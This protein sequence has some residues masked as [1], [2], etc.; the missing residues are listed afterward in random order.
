MIIVLD[1]QIYNNQKYGGISR[2][3]TEV[4]SN[5]KKEGIEVIVPLNFSKN[6]YFNESILSE[7]NK[8]FDY[9][10][11]YFLSLIGVSIRKRTKKI[12]KKLLCKTLL[13][14]K[15][16]VFIPTFY[17]T[18]FLDYIGDKPFVL[19]VYDMIHELFPC[20]FEG[21][22]F[23]AKNKLL[24]ME[25][26]T[27]I[28]AV[29][30]NTKKDI[31]KIYPHIN[32]D[33]IEVIYHGNSV[34]S[35]SNFKVDLP[36]NYLLFVGARDN[37]KN[38]IFFINSVVELLKENQ[39]LQ[40]ICAGGGDFSKN[41]I[42]FLK[43][44]N[45]LDRVKYRFFKENELGAY[46]RNAKCFVF[47][48]EYEGFGIPVLEAMANDC[49]IILPYNSSFPEVAGEAGIFYELNNSE[50]L[51][52]KIKLVLNDANFRKS[53]ISLGKEQVEKFSW[54]KASKQCLEVYTEALKEK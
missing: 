11:L 18:Y 50:A 10:F 54:E 24:L 38:F 30:H 29:S 2:Y 33:K 31:L 22:E 47:P 5:L 4:F 45:L 6:V 28:I 49:P 17:D 36:D 26:A 48:S 52:E 3:Y 35:N 13:N 16:D 9:F 44:L 1:P 14:K 19:T 51:L 42:S 46:Y 7:K 32:A 43:S 27:K 8:N 21:Y 37:Y 53:H 25:K 39:D 40:I 12:N 41:E 23:I 15:Y 34:L 20:Y